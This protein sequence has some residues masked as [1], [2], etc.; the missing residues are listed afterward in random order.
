MNKAILYHEAAHALVGHQLGM[1]LVLADMTGLTTGGQP[2]IGLDASTVPAGE[3]PRARAVSALAGPIAEAMH[4]ASGVYN[5]RQDGKVAEV[6]AKAL[7]NSDTEK[8]AVQVIEWANEAR[9]ILS[10]NQGALARIVMVLGARRMMTGAELTEI[11]ASAC[12]RSAVD[13]ASNNNAA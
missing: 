5:W 6:A 8:C 13:V 4:N 7:H 12:K 1:R 2:V 11:V 3:R 9:A 10:R